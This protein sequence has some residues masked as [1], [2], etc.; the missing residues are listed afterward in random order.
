MLLVVN[1]QFAFIFS[2]LLNM[3][4]CLWTVLFAAVI[5][6]SVCFAYTFIRKIDKD[7]A[8]WSLYTSYRSW[9]CGGEF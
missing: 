2:N 5:W 9:L 7:D 4:F 6:I 8:V 3:S 1:L